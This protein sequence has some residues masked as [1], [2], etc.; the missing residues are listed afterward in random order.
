MPEPE[1]RTGSVRTPKRVFTEDEQLYRPLTVEEDRQRTNTH[2]EQPV[3]F[4]TTLTG[5]EWNVYSANLWSAV[6]DGE[7][8][9]E[10]GHPGRDDGA[11]S[12]HADHGR[13][14][15][16]GRPVDLPEHEIW[17]PGRA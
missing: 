2:Y 16:V 1:A 5:G 14:L 10:A 15:R 7:P 17:R 11:A 13:R 6:A 8:G 9:T 12:R 4:F 3:E